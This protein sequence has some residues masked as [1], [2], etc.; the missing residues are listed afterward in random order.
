MELLP[1]ADVR[2]AWRTV[3]KMYDSAHG[4]AVAGQDVLH[5]Q[6]VIMGVYS[7]DS[8][9]SYMSEGPGQKCSGDVCSRSSGCY[10]VDDVVRSLIWPAAAYL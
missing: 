7:D 3:V 9:V 8:V 10:P 4:E 2:I 1:A 6:I 5:Y